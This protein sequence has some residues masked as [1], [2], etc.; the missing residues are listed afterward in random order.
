M[1]PGRQD[2]R[3]RRKNL[4]C[5]CL[6]RVS[7]RIPSGRAKKGAS[8]GVSDDFSGSQ[9]T[10]MRRVLAVRLLTFS[11]SLWRE[12]SLWATAFARPFLLK[13]DT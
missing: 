10:P 1:V 4:L 13:C 6:G 9:P 5:W 7:L 12:V 3:L 11:L 2:G 8:G